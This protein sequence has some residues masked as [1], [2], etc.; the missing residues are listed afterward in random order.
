MTRLLTELNE[1]IG[2]QTVSVS[3]DSLVSDPS[4]SAYSAWGALL[5]DATVTAEARNEAP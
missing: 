5:A 2:L 3:K 1:H 4:V